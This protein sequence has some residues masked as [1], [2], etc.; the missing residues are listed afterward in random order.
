VIA[1]PGH[2]IY[3]CERGSCP[4]VPLDPNELEAATGRKVRP[5]SRDLLDKS[6][7]RDQV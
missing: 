1:E 3:L 2:E 7:K 6:Q 4:I 5:R